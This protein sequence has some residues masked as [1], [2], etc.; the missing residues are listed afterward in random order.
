MSSKAEDNAT[1][2]EWLLDY[3]QPE[4]S[5][6]ELDF[7]ASIDGVATLSPKQQAKLDQIWLE[8]VVEKRR[9]R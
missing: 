4:L 2:I 3:C 8:V 5:V 6:W 7:L 1:G 9:T